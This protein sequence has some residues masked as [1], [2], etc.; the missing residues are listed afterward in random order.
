MTKNMKFLCAL[1]LLAA[2][3]LASAQEPA[4]NISHARHGN[5]ANAQDLVR[6]AF[7]YVTAAQ[8]ANEFDLGGHAARAKDL[9]RQANDELR[10]AATAANQR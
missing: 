5:L 2:P 10:M 3:S 7:D 4:Q 9:L 1:S 6:Q 8:E